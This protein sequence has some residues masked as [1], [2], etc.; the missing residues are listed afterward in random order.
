[1][2]RT[3]IR[4]PFTL[5][6]AR[7]SHEIWCQQMA[8]EGWSPGDRYDE[9]ARVHDGMRPFDELSAFDREYILEGVAL[10]EFEEALAERVGFSRGPAREFTAEEL[11]VGLPVRTAH[12]PVEYGTV[13]SW[14]ARDP[15]SVRVDTIRVEW[16]DGSIVEHVASARELARVHE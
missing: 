12:E 3:A 7:L 4:T 8:D 1:M 2:P 14:D 9:D 16:S 13:V 5:K 15:A 10:E 11:H 6:I